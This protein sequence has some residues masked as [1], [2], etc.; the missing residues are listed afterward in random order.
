MGVP[1][2]F[3][4]IAPWSGGVFMAGDSRI[5]DVYRGSSET[6]LER[7]SQDNAS[8]PAQHICLPKL[9]GSLRSTWEGSPPFNP[10]VKK[11]SPRFTSP[12]PLS[13]SAPST[14]RPVSLFQHV[15][16]ISSCP[17]QVSPQQ[18]VGVEWTNLEI[19]GYSHS[20][21]H[22]I[23]L[24]RR[25]AR[26]LARRYSFHKSEAGAGKFPRF[27]EQCTEGERCSCLL[28]M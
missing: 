19:N 10:P 16:N 3:C 14:P 28:V 2:A 4:Y 6:L 24:V 23:L 27:L 15:H 20:K 1:A 7:L 25:M 13:V 11:P 17:R 5:T 21:R 22:A 8:Q 26:L 18:E 12:P 9:P